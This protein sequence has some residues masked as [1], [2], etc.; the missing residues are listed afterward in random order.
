[1]IDTDVYTYLKYGSLDD[2][3][4][5]VQAE[6]CIT[7]VWSLLQLLGDKCREQSCSAVIAEDSIQVTRCGFCLKIEWKCEDGHDGKWYSS[8]IYGSGFGINYLVNTAVLVSGGSI[9]QFHRFCDFLH[10]LRESQ[11]SFY[12]YVNIALVHY[13]SM[14]LKPM[15]RFCGFSFIIYRNQRFYAAPAINQMFQ[16]GQDELLQLPE[17]QRSP[18]IVCGDARMDSPGFSATKATYSFMEHD[19]GLILHIENGDKRE[20]ISNICATLYIM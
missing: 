12:R 15:H 14:N 17:V 2:E 18:L 6:K 9:T 10:L 16:E 1:M 19:T 20:V 8:P 5:L 13:V 3:M 7:F 11:D 4:K